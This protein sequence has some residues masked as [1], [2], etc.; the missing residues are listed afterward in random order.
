[1]VNLWDYL[2]V[3]LQR[4]ATFSF[5]NLTFFQFEDL[6]KTV[7]FK[8][9]IQ[10]CTCIRYVFVETNQVKLIVRKRAKYTGL[11]YCKAIDICAIMHIITTV[12]TCCKVWY[13]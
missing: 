7:T 13:Y 9:H 2:L 12:Y 11:L 6:S 5:L 3:L 10:L 1:M 8:V 4:A